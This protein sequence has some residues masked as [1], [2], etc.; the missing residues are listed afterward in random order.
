VDLS[1]VKDAL[2][3]RWLDL[4]REKR[5]SS[6]T[7]LNLYTLGVDFPEGYA[8]AR[9]GRMHYGF[10]A[11]GDWKGEVELRGLEPGRHRVRDF[12]EGRDLGEVVAVPGK[13]PRLSVAFKDHLLLEVAP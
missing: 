2:W 9:D 4:Y 7:F 3:R 13:S 6:G 8:I 1:P 10:F 11:E 12:V 5:L